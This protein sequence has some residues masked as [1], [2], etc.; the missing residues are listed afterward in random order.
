MY[1]MIHYMFMKKKHLHVLIMCIQ[2]YVY[3]HIKFSIYIK[4]F[5]VV[6]MF[7]CCSLLFY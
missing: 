2:Y 3:T 4:V 6:K 7:I 1:C 5:I